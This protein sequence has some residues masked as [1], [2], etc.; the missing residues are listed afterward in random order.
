MRYTEIRY[1][2]LYHL[3][4]ECSN[5]RNLKVTEKAPIMLSRSNG[6]TVAAFSKHAV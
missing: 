1:A 5:V 2:T 3:V 4:Y 6:T